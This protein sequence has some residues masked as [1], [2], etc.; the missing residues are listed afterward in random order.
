[1]EERGGREEGRRR[2]GE[3]EGRGGRGGGGGWNG[4]EENEEEERN[5]ERGWVN[6]LF[7]SVTNLVMSHPLDGYLIS[8]TRICHLHAHFLETHYVS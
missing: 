2:G 8:C 4:G 3:G 5:G 1:M 7:E 6:K